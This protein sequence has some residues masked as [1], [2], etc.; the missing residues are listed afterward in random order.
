[1]LIVLN[2]LPGEEFYVLTKRSLAQESRARLSEVLWINHWFILTQAKLFSL[3]ETE[4]LAWANRHGLSENGEEPCSY[5]LFG[6][7]ASY[8]HACVCGVWA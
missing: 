6:L 8:S 7:F 1:V 5:A 4:V 3:S 2:P